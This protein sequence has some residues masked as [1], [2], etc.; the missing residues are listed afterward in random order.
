MKADH[1]DIT[2]D[3][4]QQIVQGDSAWKVVNSLLEKGLVSVYENM[5]EN[6]Q[7]KK[8]KY[9]FLNV[10]YLDEERLKTLFS[11]LEK[12]PKQLNILLAYLHLKQTLSDVSQSDLLKQSEASS[13]QLSALVEKKIFDIK[14]KPISL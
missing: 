5:Y 4:V 3:E 6:Y 2:I 14:K 8:E 7:P 13:A 1:K 9:V 12:A 11:Q 10:I